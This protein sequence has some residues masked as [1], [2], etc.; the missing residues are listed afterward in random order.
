MALLPNSASNKNSRSRTKHTIYISRC[1]ITTKE[2]S[3]DIIFSHK[4]VPKSKPQ[5]TKNQN[6]S[7]HE[8]KTHQ[9]AK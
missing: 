6:P 8:R 2:T 3:K 1:I 5:V 4:Q 7:K 9:E